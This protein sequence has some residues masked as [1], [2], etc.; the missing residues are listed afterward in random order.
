MRAYLPA[1]GLDP[2]AVQTEGRPGEHLKFE[3][4]YLKSNLMAPHEPE[5][6]L[7]PNKPHLFDAVDV[8]LRSSRF[9]ACRYRT[10]AAK[11]RAIE[12]RSHGPMR[13]RAP[14]TKQE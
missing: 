3:L 8:P 6:Y 11:V 13:S 2:L 4:S 10:D 1:C 12:Y 7:D 5:P 9:P 14:S